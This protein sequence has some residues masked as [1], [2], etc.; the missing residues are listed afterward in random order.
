[1]RLR[2]G[3]PEMV[4]LKVKDNMAVVSWQVGGETRRDIFPAACVRAGSDA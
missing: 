3:G 4:V 1:M 2:S